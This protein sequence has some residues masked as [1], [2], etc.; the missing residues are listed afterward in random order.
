[1]SKQ[2]KR[3]CQKSIYTNASQLKMPQTT[4]NKSDHI[5]P[6]HWLKRVT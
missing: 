3:I 6:S 1:M 5:R 4:Q 2:S